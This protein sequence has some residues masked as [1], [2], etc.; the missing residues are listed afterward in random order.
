MKTK[1]I[2][3]FL[4]CLSIPLIVGGISGFATTKGLV[5]WF[6]SL[7]K[8][9][10]NPPNY[11]F[12]PVWTTLYTM[13]GISLFLIWKSRKEINIDKALKIFAIQLTLNFIWSFLFFYFQNLGLAFVEI[14]LMWISI[15]ICI[16]AFYKI[17][18]IAA[19][20]LIPYIMWVSF[21]SVLN[22]AFWYLN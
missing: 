2:I 19:Y 18:K 8:P 22:G 16:F 10:F 21:A 6:A 3:P 11:L 5:P 13:M 4:I 12:A 1:L 9:S 17:N 20:L 14:I 7:N 15:L